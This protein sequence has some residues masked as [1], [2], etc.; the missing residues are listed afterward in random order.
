MVIIIIK[1]NILQVRD[2]KQK[3]KKEYHESLKFCDDELKNLKND[4]EYELSGVIPFIDRVYNKMKG[5]NL[6]LHRKESMEKLEEKIDVVIIIN[7]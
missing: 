1:Q 7:Y 4:P 2:K 6:N 3:S 5:A